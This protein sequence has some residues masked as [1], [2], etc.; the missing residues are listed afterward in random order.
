MSKKTDKESEI[1]E[2][3]NNHEERNSI[4]KRLKVSRSTISRSKNRKENQ[5]PDKGVTFS[6]KES[7]KALTLESKSLTIK[8]AED[9]IKYAK[10]DMTKW[11]KGVQKIKTWD[12]TM[13][14]DN[15]PVTKTNYA[16]SVELKPKEKAN[17]QE[18]MTNIIADL[19]QS[20]P[21]R[22]VQKK[23]KSNGHMLEFGLYDSHF[24]MLAWN[25]EVLHGDYDLNIAKQ[26]YAN[27]I[28][29]I[30]SRNT[31]YAITKI[32]FPVGNDLFH[33]N[34]P[35]NLT[36]KAKN[37]LDVDGRHLKVF[38]TGVEAVMEAI[39]LCRQVAPVKILWVP[40]NHDPETSYYLT[41]IVE[42][43]FHGESNVITDRTPNIYKAIMWGQ[44]FIGFGHG[45]KVKMK[46]LPGLFADDF[47]K[48]WG[49]ATFREIHTAHFHHFKTIE[50][51]TLNSVGQT[52][53]RQFPSLCS[54][55][56]WH[57]ENGYR[58]NPA[59][60]ALYWDKDYG[61]TNI[62][63]SFVKYNSKPK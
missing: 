38:E 22:Y 14:I 26:V 40:G 7:D 33:T 62:A 41:R 54:I 28:E 2:A 31:G 34:N 25:P 4:S 1:W 43:R 45:D 19:R 57:Y 32:L 3:L 35:D 49:N 9:L 24:G 63:Q 44:N 17:F 36:P 12:V 15:E 16:I 53:I 27:A 52:V 60:L 58:H 55:D 21:K 37:R 48:M 23:C 56:A 5:Y 46:A 30:L 10:V 59:A 20:K 6:K 29:D 42:E 47:P 61:L 50:L 51:L 13:K 39:E 8:T 18:A 11:D